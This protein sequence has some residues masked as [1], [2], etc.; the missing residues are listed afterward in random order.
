LIGYRGNQQ[1]AQALAPALDQIAQIQDW[2]PL[3]A[4]LRRILGGERGDGPLDGLD[5]IDTAIASEILTRL[6]QAPAERE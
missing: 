3:V 5:D 4:V 2:A 1:A 6:A